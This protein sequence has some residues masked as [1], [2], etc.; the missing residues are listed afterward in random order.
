[1]QEQP[2]KV[3]AHSIVLNNRERLTATGILRIE[4]FSPEAIAAKTGDGKL[5]IKGKNLYVESLDAESGDMLVRG[6]ICEICYE[7]G[8]DE[9]SFLKKLFR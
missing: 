6:R 2:A 4:Y 9:K 7:E 5:I 3:K 1:M 8:S